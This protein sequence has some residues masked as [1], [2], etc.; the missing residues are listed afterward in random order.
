MSRLKLSR[1]SGFSSKIGTIAPNSGRLDTLQ[2]LWGGGGSGACST[3][4]LRSSNCWKCIKIVNPTITT[5]FLHHF[6]YLRSH[7]A[8]LFGS[9]G[10][11][12][13][14]GVHAHLRA[15]QNRISPV[16]TTV[17]SQ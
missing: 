10:G 9:C 2:G 16:N 1:D 6:K 12:G 4:N 13:G 14:G 8:D 11:C 5:L 17:F 3:G 15:C 7:Q